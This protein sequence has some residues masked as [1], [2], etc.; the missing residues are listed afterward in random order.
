MKK[1]IFIS[2]TMG[3]G[4]STVS[5]LCSELLTRSV[6]LD[7]DWCWMMHPF[8]VSDQTKAMVLNNI[9]YLLNQFLAQPDFDYILFSWVMDDP[10]TVRSIL[11]RL[12]GE[13]TFNHFTLS[14]SPAQLRCQLQSDIDR[15]LRT[16]ECFERSLARLPHYDDIDS[17]KIETT[18][19][20]PQ[21]IAREILF[22]LR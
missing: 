10:E 3:S 20:E 22:R 2:G 8:Q 6:W 7:G 1:V 9:T 11:N 4:K 21:S 19:R 17:E 14:P 18:G 15:G 12:L 13:F 16:P 5:R